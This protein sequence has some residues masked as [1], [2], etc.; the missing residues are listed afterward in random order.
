MSTSGSI[1]KVQFLIHI[2]LPFYSQISQ[3]PNPLEPLV[4]VS[5]VQNI[6]AQKWKNSVL[7]KRG[8]IYQ[9]EL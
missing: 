2:N 3:A 6:R 5:V 9:S 8:V 7:M 1:P 4:K